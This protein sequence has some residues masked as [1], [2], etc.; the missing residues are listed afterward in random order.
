MYGKAIRHGLRNTPPGIQPGIEPT[1]SDFLVR[2]VNTT[3]AP[4][5][6]LSDV[7]DQALDNYLP[8][9]Y[10]SFRFKLK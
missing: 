2:S 9:R 7:P 6:S 10:F 8:R 5:P 3:H 1:S 4:S